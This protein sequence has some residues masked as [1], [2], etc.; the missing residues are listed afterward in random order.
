MVVNTLNMTIA[1]DALEHQQLRRTR[2]ETDSR[3]FENLLFVRNLLNKVNNDPELLKTLIVCVP[4]V[5]MVGSSDT[6]PYFVWTL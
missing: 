1:L 2:K 4:T 6:S 5:P 3:K